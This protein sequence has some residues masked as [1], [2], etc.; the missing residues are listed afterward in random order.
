MKQ[1]LKLFA[2]LLVVLPLWGAYTLSAQSFTEP[3]PGKVIVKD[4]KPGK[5][6]D[7]LK[8]QRTSD[9]DIT[10]LTI[11]GEMDARDFRVFQ[12]EQGRGI[13]SSK[14]TELDLSGI[15][16]IAAY[17][18]EDGCWRDF[19]NPYHEYPENE[20]PQGAMGADNSWQAVL[21]SV[22]TLKLPDCI[23]A[24]G[25]YS[26]LG[27]TW[28]TTNSW[29]PVQLP[30]GTGTLDL[31]N[32]KNLKNIGKNALTRNR[33]NKLILPESVEQ[34]GAGIF[35]D[36]RMMEEVN[37][38]DKITE[39]PEAAFKGT[40]KLG[41]FHIPKGVTKIGNMAFKG[42]GATLT[43][44]DGVLEIGAQETFRSAGRFKVEKQ[45]VITFPEQPKFVFTNRDAEKYPDDEGPILFMT[46][47][48]SKITNKRLSI[49]EGVI[50]LDEGT[51]AGTEVE[52]LEL[53][54]YLEFIKIEA[55]NF[56]MGGKAKI[57]KIY[58]NATV[59]P[60][61]EGSEYSVKQYAET[62]VLF[63]V[64]EE[65]LAAY[66]SAPLWEAIKDNLR[67]IGSD[68]VAGP[69][70]KF[71]DFVGEVGESFTLEPFAPGNRTFTFTLEE[72][73]EAIAS[74][75]GNILT[76]KAEG[77]VKVTAAV[78]TS[79]DYLKDEKTITVTVKDYSWLQAPTLAVH[80]N[81]AVVVGKGKEAFT[82]I[83]V[84]GKEGNDLTDLTGEIK[85][86]ATDDTGQQKI[87]LVVK[88]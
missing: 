5:L 82:K 27:H 55:F 83:S 84:N 30:D 67:T 12:Y 6:R 35:A 80:G 75:E 49:P 29:D 31:S 15:T 72:G 52:E 86:E 26:L 37:L 33:F 74:L 1:K 42:S 53:P 19:K 66:Q 78:P 44:P 50:G 64:P 70:E 34:V 16:R 45:Q 71:E 25:A 63:Y 21:G 58:L 43:L 46:F 68:A 61:F 51:F 18:G 7:V 77:E 9:V 47:W 2:A 54:E 48:G 13:S 14:I 56:Y 4:M 3:E 8:N 17:K 73:K 57:D 81:R 32:L 87:R 62:G 41:Q 60:R 79:I 39:I 24:L 10:S 88:R 22:V 65:A 36:C 40:A 76:L 85:I 11:S 23:T 38:N 20:M 69:I 59:P 28:G